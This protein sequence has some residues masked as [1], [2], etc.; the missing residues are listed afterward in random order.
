MEQDTVKKEARRKGFKRAAWIT[1]GLIAGIPLT[2]WAVPALVGSMEAIAW[3]ACSVTGLWSAMVGSTAFLRP[4]HTESDKVANKAEG[5]G[6]VLAG[7]AML[8]A[9]FFVP[10]DNQGNT[11]TD[12][13]KAKFGSAANAP[14]SPELPPLS[15]E[16]KLAPPERAPR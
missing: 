9:S 7:V 15:I 13:L 4:T 14:V 3:I 2:T 5:T 8:G 10:M 16:F 6:L 12:K 11:L 1:A